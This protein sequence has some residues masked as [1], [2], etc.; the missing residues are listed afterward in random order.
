[1][2][3]DAYNTINELMKTNDKINFIAFINDGQIM[4]SIT[5]CLAP[6]T[7]SNIDELLEFV[8]RI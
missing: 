5:T 7:V 1:M 2:Y 3:Q 8:E 4:I 6:S